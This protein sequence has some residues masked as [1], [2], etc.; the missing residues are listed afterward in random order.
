MSPFDI[1]L[2]AR[3]VLYLPEEDTWDNDTREAIHE[4]LSMQRLTRWVLTDKA[5]KGM[6]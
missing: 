5:R 2:S 6:N 1:R 4:E 3:D